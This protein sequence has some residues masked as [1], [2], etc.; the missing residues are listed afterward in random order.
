M[1][2]IG[3]IF[4]SLEVF[5]ISLKCICILDV[6]QH[7]PFLA[8]LHVLFSLCEFKLTPSF[9]LTHPEFLKL[10]LILKLLQPHVS[11]S[12]PLSFLSIAQYFL[13]TR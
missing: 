1:L 2:C 11:R 13:S 3:Y 9:P 10:A 6:P 5:T 4:N 7:I 8:F 12:L